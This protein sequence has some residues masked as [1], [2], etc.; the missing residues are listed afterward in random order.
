[1]KDRLPM[2]VWLTSLTWLTSPL[3]WIAFVFGATVGSF[4][5]VCIYRIP[6]GTFWRHARS[7]CRACGAEIPFYLNIPIFSW[8]MLRGRTRCCKQP[9]SPQYPLVELL[10]GVVFAVIYWK[11]PFVT[12]GDSGLLWDY[13]NIIRAFHAVI[14]TCL[15]IVCSV[16]DLRFMIIPDVISLPMIALTPAVVFLHPDLDWM[17]ALIGVVAGGGSLYAI[18]WLYWLIRREV[19]M[20]MGDVKL[21]AGIGGWLGYQAII[22]TIFYGSLL[23]AVTGLGIMVVTRRLTLRSAIPFGPFLAAGAIIQLIIGPYLQDLI[24]MAASR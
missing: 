14:F 11:F 22:P 16:I 17:S 13:S 1:M 3:T 24:S 18:A 7:V 10:T 12:L 21:L 8:L 23:G 20:G 4:L 19:G 2:L 9:L 5:N 6:E 15:L